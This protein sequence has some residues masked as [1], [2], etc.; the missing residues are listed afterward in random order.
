MKKIWETGIIL[1]SAMGFW[2]MIYPDL[3]FTQ[4]VCAVICDYAE[5]P[6]T[7]DAGNRSENAGREEGGR[8]NKADSSLAGDLHGPVQD[9]GGKDIFTGL[10]EAEPGRIRLKSRLFEIIKSEGEGSGD[11]AKDR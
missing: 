11:G 7:A 5:D 8:T 6:G 1:F 9:I 4:D 2:G 3:C 10:C